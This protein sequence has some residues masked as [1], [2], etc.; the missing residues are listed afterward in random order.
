MWWV[1]MCRRCGGCGC[2]RGV[3]G[4]DVYEVWWV[5]V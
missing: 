4:E 3:V 2:V 5:D 1:W